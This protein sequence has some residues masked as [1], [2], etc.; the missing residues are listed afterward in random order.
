MI[1][2]TTM[3]HAFPRTRTN[4]WRLI[5]VGTL[6][7]LAVLAASCFIFSRQLENSNFHEAVLE[8]NMVKAKSYLDHGADVDTQRDGLPAL[9]AAVSSGNAAMVHLLLA[10]GANTEAR[11]VLERGATTTALVVAVSD[12][13]HT[14]PAIVK[15]LLAKGAAVNCRDSFGCTAL[16]GAAFRGQPA[17]VRLLLSAGAEVNARDSRG[18]TP[19]ACAIKMQ[20]HYYLNVRR[21][22][23][24]AFT[25]ESQSHYAALSETIRLLKQAGGTT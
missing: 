21:H 11:A 17:L 10:R 13:I 15:M 22:Y 1:R 12:V 4:H 19:L 23:S 8:G 2:M 3:Q 5:S 24:P 7:L 14:S 18:Y 16:Q 25:A 6:L 9:V 20:R